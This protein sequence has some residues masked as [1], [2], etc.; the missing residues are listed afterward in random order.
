MLL[1]EVRHPIPAKHAFNANDNV[2]AELMDDPRQF[3]RSGRMVT[4]VMDF[5]G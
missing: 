3:I 5:T 4:V 2:C 1:T